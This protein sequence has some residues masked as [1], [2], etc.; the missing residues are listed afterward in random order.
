MPPST[1]GLAANAINVFGCTMTPPVEF[2]R[3]EAISPQ[4]EPGRYASFIALATYGSGLQAQTPPD[5]AVVLG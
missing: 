3:V 5:G 1:T 2:E 4:P